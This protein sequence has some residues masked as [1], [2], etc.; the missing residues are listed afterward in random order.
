MAKNYLHT[1]GAPFEE[2]DITSDGEAYER[3]L[4][5]TNQLGVPVIEIE[6][7]VIVGFDRNKLDVVLRDKHFM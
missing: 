5:K 3:V 2:R 7:I 1:I 6:N 4:E